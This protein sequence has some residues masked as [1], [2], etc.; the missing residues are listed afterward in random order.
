[1]GA[2]EMAKHRIQQYPNLVFSDEALEGFQD[3]DVCPD[4]VHKMYEALGRLDAYGTDKQYLGKRIENTKRSGLWELKAKGRSKTEWRFLF[5]HISNSNYALLYF[6]LKKDELIKERY[7]A[8][9]ERIAKREG[10]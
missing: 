7:F 9:A 1:M 6:F 4:A 5:K 8:S 3:P 2:G 10:W